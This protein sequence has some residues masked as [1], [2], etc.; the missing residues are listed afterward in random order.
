[1]FTQPTIR[2]AAPEVEDTSQKS[3]FLPESPS[4]IP[5]SL[6]TKK[7]TKNRTVA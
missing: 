5:L 1:M 6:K 2:M 4:T 3:G 7:G